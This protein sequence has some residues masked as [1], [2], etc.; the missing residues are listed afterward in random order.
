MRITGHTLALAS[1]L[2]ALCA[3]APAAGERPAARPASGAASPRADLIDEYRQAASELRICGEETP[4]LVI[5]AERGRL[6]LKRNGAALWDVPL[7]V[8]GDAGALARFADGF[9]GDDR[10]FVRTIRGRHLYSFSGQNPDS[11]LVIV[12]EVVRAKTD[13]M[14]RVVPERFDIAWS[15]DMVLEIRTDRPGTRRSRVSNLFASLRRAV[16][17]WG[18]GERLVVRIDAGRAV[19]L[20]RVA[21]K[22]LPTIVYPDRSR[23]PSSG[24]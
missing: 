7:R 4:Y 21:G 23:S 18:K 20:Y 6:L 17:L 9:L 2:F 11:V 15:G 3:P 24:S 14:Q 13:L 12:S 10:R 19:T 22:G 8:D 16:A 5:D 1:A